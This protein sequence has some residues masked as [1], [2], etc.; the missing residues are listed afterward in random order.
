MS[1]DP[2]QPYANNGTNFVA[3]HSDTYPAIDPTKA[4]LSGKY[5][6]ITGA[7]KGVGK[8]AAISYAQAGASGIAIGAR[9]PLEQVSQ[10]M[11]AAAKKA[12][13]NPPNIVTLQLDVTSGASVSAA[14]A[15]VSA[16][17]SGRL[18]ILINNAGYLSPFAPIA[19]T[20]PDDW[21]RDWEVNV[22]G[23][24]LMTRAFIPLLARSA[25]RTVVNITS[26]GA[27]VPVPGAS[28]YAPAKL[29]VL[30]FSEYIN[31]D[32]AAEGI[33]AFSVHPGGVKTELA[34]G[35]PEALHAL[36]VDE[37]EL[38]ADSLVWLTRERREWLA[39]RYV[40]VN[41]DV[42]ELEGRKEDILRGDLLKVRMA[43]NAFPSA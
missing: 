30:R 37:V 18:D 14:L 43:V 25:A 33:L 19:D 28:A 9:S 12:G 39:G 38:A 6:L 2:G 17:F 41:W 10:Q 4:D 16:A 20:D 21:W 31:S 13:R 34:L 35:M 32:H 40:S 23:V 11:L 24:Y 5:V 29:A 42:E 3:A 8:A 36:L 7:S 15:Q 27:H 26:I 1:Q 22:K